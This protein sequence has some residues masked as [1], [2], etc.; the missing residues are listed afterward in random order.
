VEALEKDRRLLLAAEM[1]LPGRAWLEFDIEGKN[2]TSEICQTAIFDP[3]GLTGLAYWY[4]LYPLH[5]LVFEGMLR[6]IA[7]AAQQSSGRAR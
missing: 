7:R 6:G 5:Y 4:G 3:M 2:G 1:K